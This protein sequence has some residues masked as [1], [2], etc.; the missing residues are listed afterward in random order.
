MDILGML[1]FVVCALLYFTLHRR[2]SDQLASLFLWI[3]GI[4]VGIIV[5]AIW[6]ASILRGI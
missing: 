3:S 6:V 4:G 5:G 2:K 1:V